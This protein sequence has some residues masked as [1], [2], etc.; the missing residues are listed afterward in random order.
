MNTLRRYQSTKGLAIGLLFVNI[1][2]GLC[3][4]FKLNEYYFCGVKLPDA[5]FAIGFTS[6]SLIILT[7]LTFLGRPK[8]SD[9]EIL[10]EVSQKF[11]LKSSF[12]IIFVFYII[13]A[14]IYFKDL[15]LFIS[16]ILSLIL[17]IFV[18]I[19]SKTIYILRKTDHQLLWH[20]RNNSNSED[21]ND[22]HQ[23]TFLWRYKIWY[24]KI[25]YVPM[26]DRCFTLFNILCIG[27]SVYALYEYEGSLISNLFIIMF[28]LI[29][30][31]FKGLEYILGLYTSLSGVC[32]GIERFTD[33]GSDYY[34]IYVTDY[35]HKREIKYRCSNIPYFSLYDKVTLIHGIFSKHV[36]KANGLKIRD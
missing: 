30:C 6:F 1:I 9:K 13:A 7:L 24:N 33:K 32:T 17:Y 34:V 15:N 19:N 16:A 28:F 35:T 23:S 3:Q 4:I 14:L 21:T 25:D 11:L 26:K 31:S 36:V 27:F 18:I 20:I 8:T 29:P 22:F 12:S 5:S 2:A 10:S